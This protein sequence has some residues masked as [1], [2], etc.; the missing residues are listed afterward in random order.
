M[1]VIF[2]KANIQTIFETY[3]QLKTPILFQLR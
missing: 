1:W 3:E 2:E